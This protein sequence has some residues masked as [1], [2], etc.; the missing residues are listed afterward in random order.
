MI[1]K[2]FAS[3]D[4]QALRKYFK[5][6]SWLLAEK[7]FRLGL[8]MLVGIFVARYLGKEN[9]GLLGYAVSFTGLFASIPSLGVLHLLLRDL[10]ANTENR[11]RYLGT[12]FTLQVAGALLSFALVLGSVLLLESDRQ[13]VALILIVAAGFFFQ[14]SY[15]LDY[16]FQSQVKAK[17]PVLVNSVAVT[18]CNAL[19]VLCIWQGAGLLAFVSLFLLE[20]V[21]LAIG[22]F[23]A[24]LATGHR[25]SAWRFD[26]KLAGQLLGQ[27]WFYVLAGFAVHT[28][29][30]VDQVM[31]KNMLGEGP[32]GLYA[33][34]VKFSEAFYFIPVVIGNSLM[35]AIT[36]ARQKSREIYYDRFQKLYNLLAWMAIGIALSVSVV[37]EWL[38]LFLLK[39]DYAGSVPVLRI[40]VWAGVFVFVGAAAD[41]WLLQEGLLSHLLFRTSLGA[42]LNVGLNFWLIPRQGIEGAALATLFSYGAAFYLSYAISHK[43]RLTFKLQ[44]LAFVFPLLLLW[45][46]IGKK[47]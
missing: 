9:Y 5:N 31:I 22:Y 13:A 10:A 44:S 23:A 11:D 46:Q 47:K 45:K 27:G 28:Y 41:R 36:F 3:F 21:L 12:A 4:P 20:Q 18:V 43:T 34:A 19:R 7:V 26:K 42:V 35:P 2:L 17:Y 37:A 16:Y 32:N 30:K 6:T 33:A 29:L 40:H 38:I 25:V 39:E 24:Y 8:T 14:P 1:R 15:V